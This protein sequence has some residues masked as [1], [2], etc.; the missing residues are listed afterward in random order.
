[1]LEYEDLRMPR[2]AFGLNS[3]CRTGTVELMMPRPTPDTIL[4][5][6]S[7]ARPV[8]DA[9][10]T[11]PMIMIQP[12][13]AMDRLRPSPSPN[14]AERM[15]PKKHPT[16][17]NHVRLCFFMVKLRL[18]KRISPS[19][20]ATMRPMVL[21]SGFPNVVWNGEEFTKTQRISLLNSY[22]Q[23]QRQQDRLTQSTHEPIVKSNKHE[24]KRCYRCDSVQKRSAL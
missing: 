4:P 21:A 5:T 20:M 13:W 14:M 9:C 15:E 12:P 18:V 19:K 7:C 2:V 6:I 24:S 16:K 23:E 1:M 11:A 17:R 8:D 10:N 22:Q 3:A